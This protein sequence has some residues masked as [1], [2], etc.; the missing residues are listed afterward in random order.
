MHF[1]QEMKIPMLYHIHNRSLREV[2]RKRPA[3]LLQTEDD[4][5]DDTQHGM[6]ET[7]DSMAEGSS[8]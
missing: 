4:Q 3:V 1:L 7:S 5:E 6:R 8:R 2:S